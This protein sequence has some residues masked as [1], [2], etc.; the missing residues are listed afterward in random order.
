MY[1]DV[2]NIII[3]NNPSPYTGD[4]KFEISFETFEAINDGMRLIIFNYIFL[5]YENK[6]KILFF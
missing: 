5:C 6:L 1:V 4:F 2:S 3:Q